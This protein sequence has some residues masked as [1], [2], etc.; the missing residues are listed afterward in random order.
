MSVIA[1]S[2]TYSLYG[3]TLKSAVPL[4]C[5][6]AE[7]SLA[8]PDIAL[9]ECGSDDIERACRKE[10]VSFRDEGFWQSSVFADGSAHVAWKEHFEF[11]VSAGAEQVLWQ[12][13]QE[14]P[15][16]VFFTYFLGQVFSYCLLAR[17]VEPLHATAMLVNDQA[18]AFLGDSG[19]GK[20]TLAATFL[21]K[22]YTLLTDDVLALAFKG[23][24]VWVRPGIARVKL[25][26][27]SADAVFSGRRS[28][29]MNSFT[30]KMIFALQDSQ[31]GSREVPL[32]AL[33]VLPHKPSQSRIMVRRLSGRASFLPIVQNTFNDTV[34]HPDRLKQQFAFAAR[35]ASLI[36]IKRLSYPRRLDLLPSVADAILADVSRESKP[37]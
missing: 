30:S 19:V 5:P 31:H 23:E 22:G 35:L 25:N 18:I 21:Q 2:E 28:I 1:R 15:N 3:L 33:Y 11:V 34:L 16:E 17:G 10:R 27:D 37:S 26:P 13:L 24:G 6:T 14:V 12:K 9:V 36:P 32:R 4:P 8:S 29:P 20:S 7:P